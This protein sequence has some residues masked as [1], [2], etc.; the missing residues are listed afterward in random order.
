MKIIT[1]QAVTTLFTILNKQKMIKKHIKNITT[2]YTLIIILKITLRKNIK[3][4]IQIKQQQSKMK[5]NLK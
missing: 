1:I 2:F 5:S 4:Q 3:E